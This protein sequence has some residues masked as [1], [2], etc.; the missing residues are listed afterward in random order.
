MEANMFR[1]M[2]APAANTWMPRLGWPGVKAGKEPT[3]TARGTRHCRGHDADNQ[4]GAGVLLAGAGPAQPAEPL[5]A[6]ASRGDGADLRANT[7]RAR[8]R[9]NK[10]DVWVGGRGARRVTRSPYLPQ[11]FAPRLSQSL[12]DPKVQGKPA[13]RRPGWDDQGTLPLP[14]TGLL[15]PVAEGWRLKSRQI[16]GVIYDSLFFGARVG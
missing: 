13:R 5:A 1:P 14:T 11:L 4:D 3:A 15:G 6:P 12:H 8:H 10:G 2:F 7:C 9:E 16:A